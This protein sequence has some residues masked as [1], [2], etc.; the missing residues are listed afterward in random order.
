MSSLLQ[1]QAQYESL[2]NQY[3]QNH[4]EAAAC[5]ARNDEGR[6]GQLQ[7]MYS[8]NL[9]QPI[10]FDSTGIFRQ[11]FRDCVT[12]EVGVES[13][14]IDYVLNS[15]YSLSLYLL[16]PSIVVSLKLVQDY[17]V[18]FIFNFTA[19]RRNA[20]G[21]NVVIRRFMVDLLHT[22]SGQ[23]IIFMSEEYRGT[24]RHYQKERQFYLLHRKII[25]WFIDNH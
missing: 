4:S 19:G 2:A 23:Y 9:L 7:F 21:S 6:H 11:L 5:L 18:R 16:I 13:G 1:L 3:R 20:R 17:V 8:T 10:C 12:R 25:R 15:R 22:V 24:Y 14:L